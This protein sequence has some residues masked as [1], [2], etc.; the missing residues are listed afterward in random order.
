MDRRLL[1]SCEKGA[2]KLHTTLRLEDLAFGEKEPIICIRK[3]RVKFIQK[4][5]RKKKGT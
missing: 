2:W 5:N 1:T 4:I 3:W